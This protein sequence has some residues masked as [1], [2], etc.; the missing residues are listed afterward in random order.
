MEMADEHAAIV[1][2]LARPE[3]YSRRPDRVEHVE[4]HISHVFLAGSYACKLKKP[5]KYDFIDFSTLAARDHACREEV[6]L[7]R[8]LAPDT[9]LDV[10]PVELPPRPLLYA[11][12][13]TSRWGPRM[14]ALTPMR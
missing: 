8:C 1:L 6:R 9:Y 3:N 2:W 13:Y 5:V 14:A 12:K 4:T 7:N 10:V 11:A